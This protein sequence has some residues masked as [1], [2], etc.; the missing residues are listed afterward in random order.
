MR[1]GVGLLTHLSGRFRLEIAF[2]IA[3]GLRILEKIAAND[4]DARI[5]PTLRWYDLPRLTY[6]ATRAWL[7]ARRLPL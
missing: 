1:S 2:T 7:D 3:G 5:R 4:F 6:L